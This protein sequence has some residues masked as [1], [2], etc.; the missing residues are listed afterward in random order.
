MSASSSASVSPLR[1]TLLDCPPRLP[2]SRL[3]RI[4]ADGRRA[5][6]LHRA[7][8]SDV[9]ARFPVHPGCAYLAPLLGQPDGAPTRSEFEDA[10]LAFCECFELPRPKVN[11]SVC[12]YEVDALFAGERLIVELDGWDFHQGREAFESDRRRDADTLVGGF[13]T[14]RITWERMTTSPRDEAQRLRTILEGR[15][16]G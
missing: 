12:G 7:A 10:C 11:T 2:A 8:L 5:G 1:R 3:L 16:T 13:A 15:R 6:K 9:I 4:A 14:V